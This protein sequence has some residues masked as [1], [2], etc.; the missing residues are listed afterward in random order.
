M[1]D[2][3][4]PTYQE[5][6]SRCKELQ[7]EI[8]GSMV[9]RQDLIDMRNV[10]DRDLDCFKAIQ[11]Y[12]RRAI[13]ARDLTALSELTVESIIEAFSV[14]SA[15]LFMRR[16]GALEMRSAYGM[17]NTAGGCR[18][19]LSHVQVRNLKEAGTALIEKVNAETVPWAGF[20]LDQVI[21]SPFLDSVGELEGLLVGGISETK[22]PYYDPLSNE[23][24]P[25]FMVFTQQ[26]SSSFHN[27]QSQELIREQV[28][29]LER[30]VTELSSLHTI[31]TAITSILEMDQLL[32]A[33]LDTIVNDLGYDRAMVMLADLDRNL[34]S[35]GR[36]IGSD[37]IVRY[38]EA[39]EL[40]LN[41]K[42]SALAR[43]VL[44]GKPLLVDDMNA[45]DVATN[46][47]VIAVLNTRSFLAVPL[48]I[49]RR[50]I[51]VMAVDNYN[52]GKK[53]TRHDTHLMTTLAGQVAISIENAGLY[54]DM[55][56]LNESLEMEIKE[57]EQAQVALSKAHAE[58]EQRVTERTAE[59]STA[60]RQLWQE[61]EERLRIE[62][63]LKKARDAAESASRA[64]SDFLANMSHELR[65]PMNA[66]IGFSEMILDGIYGNASKQIIDAVREIQQS[67][68]HLLD[69]IND[70]LDISKIEAGRMV[71]NLEEN[72][73]EDPIEAVV[74]RM[75]SLAN[76]KGLALLPDLQ[77]EL[78]TFDFD[79][80]R[81]TQVLQNLV[82]NAVKF[83]RSGEIRIGAKTQ[84]HEVHFWVSD[85]GIGISG[86]DCEHIFSEFQQADSSIN[87][88]AQGTGLGLAI[89]KRFVEM[90]GGR[91]WVESEVGV[92]STFRFSLPV[93]RSR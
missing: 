67:G 61:V 41:E 26:F 55:K 6:E 68:V 11:S 81:I 5:L 75:T 64:K 35:H 18:L 88:E 16:N 50:S 29:D 49:Q 46:E 24:I 62:S 80:Q 86:D 33:V 93:R 43:V 19:G 23:I 1:N 69:L 34:L 15:A 73:P 22:S 37:E 48:T 12:S 90:H 89:S 4:R 58:L 27:L 52:T 28:R 30:M 21:L 8:L 85:T 77:E 32:D 74:G 20:G 51:G 82:G 7:T 14:E 92:G 56:A 57:R 60:N 54:N 87:R 38:I 10:L 59:L 44:S 83:T 70:V 39:L 72:A 45:T 47:E 53:L 63:E 79:L 31:G 36:A 17:A 13:Q 2:V 40:P 42:K 65:T 84:E 71:L 3:L 66:V 78:P 25:S 91:L 9:V 76:E